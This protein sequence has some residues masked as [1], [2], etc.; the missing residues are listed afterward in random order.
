MS[1]L[2][3]RASL[4]GSPFE[5]LPCGPECETRTR[6]ELGYGTWTLQKYNLFYSPPMPMCIFTLIERSPNGPFLSVTFM[7]IGIYFT[8]GLRKFI[9]ALS[10]L[11]YLIQIL[12]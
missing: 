12:L 5:P 9:L 3:R 2:T 1:E 11:E 6:T 8:H 10:G 4:Y 7:F